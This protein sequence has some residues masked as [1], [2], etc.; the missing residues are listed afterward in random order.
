MPNK[1]SSLARRS[2]TSSTS[3]SPSLPIGRKPQQQQQHSSETAEPVCFNCGSTETASRGWRTS[4]RGERNCDA[5]YKYE[6]K[7]GKRRILGPDGKII[8]MP[9]SG[10]SS[11]AAKSSPTINKPSPD[12]QRKKRSIPNDDDVPESKKPR[13]QGPEVLFADP[14]LRGVAAY[15]EAMSY[16]YQTRKA[17]NAA[18]LEK[19]PPDTSISRHELAQH[20]WKNKTSM[21]SNAWTNEHN[22]AI[23]P[24]KIAKNG[25]SG[26]RKPISE[27]EDDDDEDEV[28]ST[29][30]SKPETRPHTPSTITSNQ[31][32]VTQRYIP[33]WK[34]RKEFE[35]GQKVESNGD[36]I[37]VSRSSLEAF[38]RRW[39]QSRIG[40][41]ESLSDN[42]SDFLLD[43]RDKLK[44]GQSVALDS[45]RVSALIKEAA[46][47][48]DVA[49]GHV[50]R[51][52]KAEEA[53]RGVVGS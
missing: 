31:D 25:V 24:S 43:I 50:Q 7:T 22:G 32:S 51:V 53:W 21:V 17:S 44:M 20:V 23:W 18:T 40:K 36:M 6:C 46:A 28:D 37:Q 52:E 47:L 5:C 2:L 26:K 34:L 29:T 3:S 12:L 1:S 33:Q 38:K 45:E 8:R 13:N 48:Q 39:D 14:P 16:L 4:R 19:V 10:E 42:V 41:E 9:Q 30:H 27:D 35:P 11:L 49:E 15:E